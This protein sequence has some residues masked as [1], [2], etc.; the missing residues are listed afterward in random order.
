[1]TLPRTAAEVLSDHVVFEIE[2]MDVETITSGQMSYDLRRLRAHELIEH[3]RH[4]PLH[5]HRHRPTPR[6]LPHPRPRP[7]LARR[8]R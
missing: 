6:R 2:S 3:T 8:T 5:R 1:M 7:H 4:V